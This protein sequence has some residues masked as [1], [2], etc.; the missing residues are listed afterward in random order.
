MKTGSKPSADQ[1]A[2]HGHD[3]LA[4]QYD[5]K[6]A[7]LLSCK[8]DVQAAIKSMQGKVNCQELLRSLQPQLDSLRYEKIAIEQ[9]PD[10]PRGAVTGKSEGRSLSFWGGVQGYGCGRTAALAREAAAADAVSCLYVCGVLFQGL[11]A[12]QQRPR[13]LE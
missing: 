11:P 12:I 9:I 5:R 6:D 4:L 3:R 8:P 10:Y 13:L 2:A 1:L 7:R